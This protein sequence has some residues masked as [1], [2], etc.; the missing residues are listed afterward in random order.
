MVLVHGLE[1]QHAGRSEKS[2]LPLARFSESTGLGLLASEV[3]VG[4]VVF[5]GGLA[6]GGCVVVFGQSPPYQSALNR[7]AGTVDPA[8]V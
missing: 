7:T 5:Q 4:G 3:V 2:C 8:C 6:G 1:F